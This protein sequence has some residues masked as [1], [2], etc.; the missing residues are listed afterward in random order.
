M[1][2]DGQADNLEFENNDGDYLD[3]SETNPFGEP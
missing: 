1:A 2:N 3:L